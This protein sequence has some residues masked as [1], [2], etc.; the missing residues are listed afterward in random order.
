MLEFLINLFSFKISETSNLCT[1]SFF[2]SE[3][4]QIELLKRIEIDNIFDE[5]GSEVFD[6]DLIIGKEYKFDLS[7]TLLRSHNFYTT[8]D[9]FVKFHTKDKSKEFYILEI[10]C[11][12]K[13]RSNFFIKNYNDIIS[14]KE[15]IIN[16]SN[17]DID[18]KL[19]IYSDNRYLKI[20]YEFTGEILPKNKYILV[21]NLF[22]KFI[23]DYEKL[24]KEIKVIFKSELINFLE[25]VNEG[26]KF[27]YLFYNFSDFYEKCI[28]G[29]EY[30]LSN[31]S[32]SKVKTELDN[33]VL[34][35]SKNI[36]TVV[37]DSQN[38]LILI[39]ATII[40]G[41]TAFDTSEPFNIKN[42]FVIA[43]SV[44]FAFMMDSFIKNQKSALEIIKT[45]IDNYKNIFLDKNKS[46]ISSLNSMILK[47]FLETDNELNRQENWM[48]GIRIINW[49]IPCI[50]FI[51]LLSLIYNMH[52]H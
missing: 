17:D 14:I 7:W 43:S 23:E 20:Y 51:F 32:Y 24:S 31:F 3:S 15:F 52:S 30:Y 41:F 46:K 16:I 27:K 36:R 18:K 19:L 2:I 35:F 39:P 12:E 44:L 34:D 11:T 13:N 1:F 22:E 47:S 49:V 26:E 45:N 10:N 28:I 37:N 33:S 29:Y 38:K 50:L 6:T 4:G 25:E 21:E 9:D 48:L 40:L 5:K 42:I 8:C